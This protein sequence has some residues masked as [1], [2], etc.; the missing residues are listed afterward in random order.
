[1]TNVYFP[2]QDGYDQERTGFQTAFRH[3]PSMIVSARDVDDVLAAVRTGLPVV[4]QSTGHGTTAVA[5]GGV[6][7]NTSRMTGVR[8]DPAARTAHVEAGARWQQVIEAAAPHSLAP[9]SGS[10]PHVGVVGYTLAGG[11]GLLAR[12]FGYAADHVRSIDIVTPDGQFRHVT[13][14]SDLF[15][16]LRGGRDGF[17]VVTAV[18][19]DLMP[20]DRVYGGALVFGIEQVAAVLDVYREWTATLPE[21]VTTSVGVIMGQVVHVRIASTQDVGHLLDPLREIGPKADRVGWLPFTEAGSIYRDPETA[22]GYFGDNVL[23]SDLTTEAL[24]AVREPAGERIIDLRHL[25]GA[26]SRPPAVPNAV[27]HREAR[28]IL[29]VLS[30]LEDADLADVR[31]AHQRIFDAVKPWTVGRSLNFVYGP[32]D[33]PD[34]HDQETS[35]RLAEIRSRYVG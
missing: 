24:E 32:S 34:L 13:S 1:M 6:L 28:Y 29:R 12:E 14:D 30:P 21:T 7:V 4:A 20:V 31:A 10:T 11:I 26:L 25:G 15:W 9:L 19:I 5:S 2:G 35:A 33:G 27:S 18:E 22:H 17:G 8:I 3:E 23:L 16:A